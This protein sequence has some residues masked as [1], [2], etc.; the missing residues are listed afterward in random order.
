MP[1]QVYSRALGRLVWVD[2]NGKPLLNYNPGMG[3]LPGQAAA[4]EAD[5]YSRLPNAQLAGYYGPSVVNPQQMQGARPNDPD[6]VPPNTYRPLAGAKQNNRGNSV[7]LDLSNGQARADSIVRTANNCGDDAEQL[8][9]T[10][11]YHWEGFAYDANPDF[12]AGFPALSYVPIATAVVG[13]GIGGA[14]FEAEVDWVQG[15]SFPLNASFV[16][17]GAYVD[18]EPFNQKLILDAALSYGASAKFYSGARK[19]QAPSATTANSASF[20]VPRFATGL[21]PL[22][23]DLLV[24]PG[25]A[26]NFR[27]DI[28]NGLGGVGNNIASF[29]WQNDTRYGSREGLIPLPNIGK[30]VTITNLDANTP[31]TY[32]IFSLSF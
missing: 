1:K 4:R 22:V 30:S 5:L 14:A 31:P 7:L 8:L 9:V 2:D 15:L 29:F 24:L 28:G 13:W 6:P 32:C 27:I 11:G 20:E 18:S 12:A 26:Q 16:Q 25:A 10:L 19:T 21:L 17:I 23:T 3:S